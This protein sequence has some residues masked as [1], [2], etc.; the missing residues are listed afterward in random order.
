LYQPTNSVA[1]WLPDAEAPIALGAGR[2]HHRI[3]VLAELL[4]GEVTPHGDVA[5][6]SEALVRG[7]LLVD[8]DHALQLLVIGGDPRPNQTVGS[9]KTIEDV[10]A[11]GH[12]R[13]VEGLRRIESRRS[14]PHDRH[15]ERAFCC[16]ELA[17]SLL[18]PEEAGLD[19]TQ[20]GRRHRLPPPPAA[21]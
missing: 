19:I 2:D 6:E 17:H 14:A 7:E 20:P 4:H 3:V 8:A 9:G 15:P 13:L 16:P 12:V 11:D 21:V 18:P 1:V 10:D 5:E